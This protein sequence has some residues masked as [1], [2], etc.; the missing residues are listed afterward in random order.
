MK[1][2]LFAVV[3]CLGAI[4]A[5]RTAASQVVAD[6]IGPDT[7]VYTPERGTVTFTHRKHGTVAEC[8]AC[9]HASKPEKPFPEGKTRLKCSECHTKEPVEP[10]KTSLR[11]AY[12][13]TAEKTGTCFD[14]HNKETAAGKTTA[15][16][17]CADCH[18]RAD[19]AIARTGGL[20][21]ALSRRR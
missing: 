9:H 6:T 1:S 17:A 4:A 3:L 12:H 10:L 14:C 16:T 19:L 15:P 11:R 13:L 8:S 18:K 20:H 21:L 2:L 5:P 7:V